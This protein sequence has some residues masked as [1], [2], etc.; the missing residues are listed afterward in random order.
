M[1][2]TATLWPPRAS[3][4]RK[5]LVAAET[6]A[7]HVPEVQYAKSSDVNIAYQVSGEGPFDLVFVPGYVSISSFT[8]GSRA[9]RLSSSGCRPFRD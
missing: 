8:G 5:P 4:L 9:L 1:Q 3:R 7:M 6:V 2:R